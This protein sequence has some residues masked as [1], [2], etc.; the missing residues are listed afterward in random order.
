MNDESRDLLDSFFF[1]F[2]I[3]QPFVPSSVGNGNRNKSYFYI[4]GEWRARELKGQSRLIGQ[5][6]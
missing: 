3:S 4:S 2:P 5:Q 6:C 1:F